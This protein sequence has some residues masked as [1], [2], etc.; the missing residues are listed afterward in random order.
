L[1]LEKRVF[2][3]APPP[4]SA[5]AAGAAPLANLR[6]EPINLGGEIGANPS[7]PIGAFQTPVGVLGVALT[8]T[9]KPRLTGLGGA[10]AELREGV[11]EIR[12]LQRA[13]LRV[14][15]PLEP[16][17][18][19]NLH[20]SRPVD[21]G[22]MPGADSSEVSRGSSNGAIDLPAP[23]GGPAAGEDPGRPPRRDRRSPRSP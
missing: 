18:D 21:D 22:D 23:G 13:D 6:L 7:P 16:A 1:S 12:I 11:A 14:P 5:L 2:L 17:G 20:S 8:R 3:S 19:R 10:R 9:P 15:T 4:S